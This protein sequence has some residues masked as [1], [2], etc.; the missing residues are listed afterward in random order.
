VSQLD[1]LLAAE[2]EKVKTA[3]SQFEALKTQA[4]AHKKAVEQAE[5][6]VDQLRR[7]VEAK[8]R[9]LAA[10]KPSGPQLLAS[11]REL[12]RSCV[13]IWA[14]DAMRCL[15]PGAGKAEWFKDCPACPEMVVVPA[16][17]FTMG[18]DADPDRA[19]FQKNWERPE[20]KVA[21]KQ[22]FA[23][24]RF[25][26]TFDEWDACVAAGGCNDHRPDDNGWGRARR[27]VIKVSWHDAK[28]YGAWISKATGKNYRLLSEAER[29]YVTRADTSTRFWWGP[30]ISIGQ[31]NFGDP[32]GKTVP[33][34]SFASN[35]WGLYQVHGNLYEWVEDCWNENYL[36][37]PADGSA[38]VTGDCDSRVLR[39]GSWNV[40]SRNLRA[41]N[42]SFNAASD[43]TTKF[44][45]RVARTLNP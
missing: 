14:G 42:R 10:L 22:P 36:R 39:G 4:E 16:G 23:V 6:Q 17:T 24:G 5:V 21:I 38:W 33:V 9:E 3:H 40:T 45:F 35:P 25:A 20:H 26:V 12:H 27:P 31:A 37:A 2:K 30:S 32:L 11:A 18:D 44:G 41:A 34:D 15:Q 43:R 8:E 19:S 13:E 28:A 1:A 7:Q 29:E